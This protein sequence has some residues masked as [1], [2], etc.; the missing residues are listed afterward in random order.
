MARWTRKDQQQVSAFKKRAARR[1][2]RYT[3]AAEHASA[4]VAKERGKPR[5][6]SGKSAGPSAQRPLDH[7]TVEEL[8]LLARQRKLPGRSRMNRAELIEALQRT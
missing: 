8:Q 4:T 6:A 5:V 7:R 1:G 3:D 2:M